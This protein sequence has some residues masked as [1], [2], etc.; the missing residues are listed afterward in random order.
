MVLRPEAF[1]R[2]FHARIADAIPI[3]DA[4]P[5]RLVAI[6]GETCRRSH[7]TAKGLGALHIV[8]AWAGEEG[9]AL[10]QVATDAKSDQITAIPQLLGQIDLAGTLITID[11]MGCRKEIV[12]QVVT[13]WRRLCDRRQGQPAEAP[14]SDP[15]VL[16]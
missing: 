16:L 14:G 13:G 7:D 9:I 4:T 5:K 3:D 15:Y 12:R 6:D 1:Q 11:A 2:C 10:G 8:S